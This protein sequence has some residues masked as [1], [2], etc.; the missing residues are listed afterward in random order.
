[1]QNVKI[2][3]TSLPTGYNPETNTDIVNPECQ[4]K[5]QQ[6]IGSLLYLMLGMRPDIAFAV[7]KMSQFSA[8]PSQEHLE[9]AKYI[10]HYLMGTQNYCVV[11]DGN[12]GESL[13]AFTDSDLASNLVKC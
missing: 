4:R 5:F 3:P 7:I 9:K 8:N 12:K 10:F 6:V 1:M 11:Y 2:T 13:Q